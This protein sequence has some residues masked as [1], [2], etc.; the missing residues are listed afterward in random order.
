MMTMGRRTKVISFASSLFVIIST[1]LGVS[2]PTHAQ[3]DSV[4]ATIP[5]GSHPTGITYDYVNGNLYVTNSGGED[6]DPNDG[7]DN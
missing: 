3:A 1:I 4:I 2:A 7:D 6:N 5:V